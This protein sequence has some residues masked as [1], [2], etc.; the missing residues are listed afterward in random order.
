MSMHGSLGKRP[1]ILDLVPSR[2]GKEVALEL[3]HFADGGWPG[4]NG[5]QGAMFAVLAFML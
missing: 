4:A 3:R 1:R 5:H 2:N